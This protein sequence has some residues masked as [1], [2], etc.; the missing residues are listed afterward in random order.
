MPK[1]HRK[2]RIGDLLR[3]QVA[4][5]LHEEFHA[6][7]DTVVTVTLADVADDL[8]TAAISVSVFPD[9]ETEAAMERLENFAGEVQYRLMKR[10]R[11]KPIP[12]I[13][14]VP[15]RGI[16]NADSVDQAF[17]KLREE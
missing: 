3:E 2:E 14:F 1:A 16:A 9:S 11:F 12:R 5:I 8:E 13:R 15:D 4:K 6:P 10:I 7:E 17:Y